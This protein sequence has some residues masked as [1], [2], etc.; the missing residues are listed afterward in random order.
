VVCVPRTF[1]YEWT[2]PQFG[3]TALKCSFL[4]GVFCLLMIAAAIDLAVMST[5]GDVDSDRL[6]ADIVIV[7]VAA[8]C[9]LCCIACIISFSIH[10]G[11]R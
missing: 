6:V 7:A 10:T 1:R 11:R 3:R 8:P 4:M 2:W 5:G 9:L